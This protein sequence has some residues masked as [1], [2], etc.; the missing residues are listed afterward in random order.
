M[1]KKVFMSLI[2]TGLATIVALFVFIVIAIENKMWRGKLKLVKNPAKHGFRLISEGNGLRLYDKFGRFSYLVP[3]G[4]VPMEAEESQLAILLRP[5]AKGDYSSNIFF[6]N[7]TGRETLE[8][9]RAKELESWLEGF[10]E[11]QFIAEDSFVT[12]QGFTCLP[13][14]RKFEDGEVTVILRTYF[15]G[16]G[17]RSLQVFSASKLSNDARDSIRGLQVVNSLTINPEPKTPKMATRVYKSGFSYTPPYG[18]DERKYRT[19]EVF[20]YQKAS[21]ENNV[22][23]IVDFLIELNFSTLRNYSISKIREAYGRSKKFSILQE[24]ESATYSGLPYHVVHAKNENYG[25]PI[26]HTI[27][28]FDLGFRKLCIQYFYPRAEARF[29]L[30]TV[31]E[32]IK[33]VRLE[34][35][36]HKNKKSPFEDD[37]DFTQSYSR[38]SPEKPT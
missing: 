12:E 21:L 7:K 35:G 11:T 22:E 9:Q 30:N 38:I 18:W 4:W 23:S 27:Y 32:V 33:S 36:R 8:D 24:S 19:S 15:L 28:V 5:S 3:Q 6:I 2:F 20:G 37:L 17:K 31:E 29:N 1:S 26:F 10:P 13:L 16:L 25:E 34:K 14:Y